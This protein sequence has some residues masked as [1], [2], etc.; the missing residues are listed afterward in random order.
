MEPC[1]Q[2]FWPLREKVAA[3][4]LAAANVV[5]SKMSQ[6]STGPLASH[7]IPINISLLVTNSEPP[8]ISYICIDKQISLYG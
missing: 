8:S 5:P 6:D 1:G 2:R 7:L 4:R 3:E